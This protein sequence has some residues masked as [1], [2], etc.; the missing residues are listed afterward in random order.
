M[1]PRHKMT[2]A[3]PVQLDQSRLAAH[4]R[5]REALAVIGAK[6]A[7]GRLTQPDGLAE[8]RLKYWPEIAGR[9]I[10]DAQH[11]GRRGLLLQSLARLGQEPRVLH[12]DDRF[13]RE[14][15]EEGDFFVGERAYLAAIDGDDTQQRPIP[16]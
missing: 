5:K 13:R 14:V 12:C 6:M 15:L 8:H 4:R 1:R 11:L 16:A 7:K 3:L 9:G 2:E 10:D